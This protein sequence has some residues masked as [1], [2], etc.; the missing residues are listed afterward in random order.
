MLALTKHF[1]ITPRIFPN[2]VSYLYPSAA[3]LMSFTTI[4]NYPLPAKA[5]QPVSGHQPNQPFNEPTN[6]PQIK[7]NTENKRTYK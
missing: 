4:E 1:N 3:K 6:Q 2:F 5:T 7:P